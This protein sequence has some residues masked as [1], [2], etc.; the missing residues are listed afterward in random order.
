M[1]LVQTDVCTDN[2]MSGSVLHSNTQH[3]FHRAD[4]PW[5]KSHSDRI[6]FF[7]Y[8]I[9]EDHRYWQNF[10]MAFLQLS[11]KK[12]KREK[13]LTHPHFQMFFLGAKSTIINHK[14]KSNTFQTWQFS[15]H[16][17][18]AHADPWVNVH[19]AA[20]QHLFVHSCMKQMK[21]RQLLII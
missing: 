16:A 17:P 6:H 15:Q 20:L 21:K 19:V 10:C 9:Q 3:C 7:H 5:D 11:A 13:K 1:Y 18:W 2:H 12:Q 8:N 14:A 4:H